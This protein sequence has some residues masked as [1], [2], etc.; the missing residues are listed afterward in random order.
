MIYLL[1]LYLT[2]CLA[3]FGLR[4]IANRGFFTRFNIK[5]LDKVT[6]KDIVFT[7]LLSWI[8]FFIILIKYK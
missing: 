3:T 6:F 2:G 8:G 7:I 1:I 5:S 4:F